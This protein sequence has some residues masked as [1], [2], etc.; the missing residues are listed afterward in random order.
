MKHPRLWDQQD[1]KIRFD[2]LSAIMIDFDAIPGTSHLV[3]FDQVKLNELEVEPKEKD[4]VLIPTPTTDPN[5]PLNWSLRRKWLNM[6]CMVVYVFG[7]GVPC[8]CL[9]SVLPQIV[10]VRHIS[11]GALN[12]ST[13]YMFLFY[14]IGTYFCMPLAS[15]F[16]KRPVYLFSL[17]SVSLVTLWEAYAKTQGSFTGSKI[18]QGFLGSP[19]ETLCEVSISD[20]FFEHERGTWMSVYALALFG[21]NYAAPIV[22]GFIADGQGWQW[23]IY[24]SSI[25]T[26]VAFLFLFFFMEESNYTRPL[27]I[28]SDE[29]QIEVI[30]SNAKEANVT[31]IQPRDSIRS[32]GVE[33]LKGN[34]QI[35][36]SIPLKSKK[37]RF[38]LW[39]YGDKKW[40][41]YYLTGPFLML[42]FPVVIYS[43]FLYGASL[44]WYSVMNGTLTTVFG[45][46]PYNFSSA[47]CGLV[48][49]SLLIFAAIFNFY[50]G[51]T[52]D[53][54]KIKLAT[55]RGG[56]SNAEDRLWLLGLYMF[57]GPAALFLFGI[58]AY[59][60]IH[61][62]AVVIGAGIT[63]GSV[64]LGCTSACNYTID[65]YREMGSEAMIVVILIRNCMNFG[66]GYAITPWVNDLGYK[67]CFLSAGF[68]CFGCISTFLIMEIWGPTWR[69]KTKGRYWKIIQDRK[70]AGIS[71]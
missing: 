48:Y 34:I 43:G 16:G 1:T 24:W 35:D 46:A 63:G 64:L 30:S 69:E 12:T 21:S 5:D 71:R 2:I 66:M 62:F 53:W 3:E 26:A 31:H 70:A 37:E 25:W 55:R 68:I 15:Q 56:K 22:A 9:F 52:A 19:I 39:T 45:G 57:I 49:V 33:V 40:F 32:M 28:D 42:Q 17:F 18:V 61:W 7:I 58:G 41:I 11:L 36:S 14:G 23:V 47:M 6:F 20:M 10:E 65:T 44:F 54:L 59:Y 13:G 8:S 29:S 4:V 50:A 27:D 60:Q 67:Y 51:W 38:A